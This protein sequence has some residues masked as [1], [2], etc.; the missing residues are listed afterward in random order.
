M[1][2]S[3]LKK[4]NA[5]HANTPKIFKTVASKGAKF[6]EN[7]AKE[8]TDQ[9]KLV[10]T[11]NYRHNWN[12][13]RIEP[14]KGTYGIV[15]ENSAEYASYLEEG[16]KLKNGERWKGRFVGKRSIDD[17]E[18]YCLEQ[19]DKAFEKAYTKYQQSFTEQE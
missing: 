12:A 14:E 3:Y 18:F 15:L 9:E 4:L 17:T 16:H 13:E 2:D 10:D 6:A 1:F 5:I 8:L 19:L 11:G 7:T